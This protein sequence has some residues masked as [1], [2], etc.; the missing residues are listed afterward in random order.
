MTAKDA[1]VVATIEVVVKC[2]AGDRSGR[3]GFVVEGF[4][5][6]FLDKDR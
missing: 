2:M 5:L 4:S 1:K 6:P 3:G